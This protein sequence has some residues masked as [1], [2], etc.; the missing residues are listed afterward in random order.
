[1]NFFLD[2]RKQLTYT[3]LKFGYDLLSNPSRKKIIM[4][5][6]NHILTINV[7]WQGFFYYF[8]GR[9]SPMDR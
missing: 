4:I 6:S 3:P 7:S 2:S 1:M 5:S 8:S 9:T